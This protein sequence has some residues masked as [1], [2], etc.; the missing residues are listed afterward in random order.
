MCTED[1][2]KK[3]IKRENASYKEETP[4]LYGQTKRNRK[5]NQYI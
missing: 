5:V 2:I 3:M 4:K 1:A